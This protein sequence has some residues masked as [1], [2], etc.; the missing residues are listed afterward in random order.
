M[1]DVKN[2]FSTLKLG[3]AAYTLVHVC[4]GHEQA[5]AQIG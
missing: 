2:G 3:A 4:H 1:A 5:Q